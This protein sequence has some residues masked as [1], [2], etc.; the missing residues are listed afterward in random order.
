MKLSRTDKVTLAG[1]YLSKFNDSALKALGCTGVWQAFNVIGYSLEA[2]PASVKNYRDEFDHEISKNTP[3]HPRKGWNRPLKTRSQKLYEL[4]ADT[5]FGDF[6]DLV[7]SFLIPSL[8]KEKLVASVTNQAVNINLAQRLM[9]G[10]A[11]EAYFKKHHSSINSFRNYDI[12]DVTSCGCGYD[13]HLSC[14]LDFYCVEVKGINTKKGG[15]LMTEK[16]YALAESL[17]ERYCLFVVRDFERTPFHSIYFNPLH[18]ELS[19]TPQPKT[20]ISYSAYLTEVS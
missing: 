19:F 20:V 8:E 17:K 14:Q 13:F 11:A 18:G 2:G 9:T 1:L 10:Q 15:I 16:E 7:K 4:F 5:N 3:S 6:T 12:E